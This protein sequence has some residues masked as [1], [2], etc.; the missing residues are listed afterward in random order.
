M[1]G[2]KMTPLVRG[3]VIVPVPAI[4]VKS[5]LTELGQ[6]SRPFTYDPN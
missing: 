3:L 1:D 2:I 5:D 6:F 4:E